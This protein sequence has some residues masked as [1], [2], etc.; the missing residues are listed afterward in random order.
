MKPLIY[1]SLQINIKSTLTHSFLIATKDLAEVCYVFESLIL[2][3][4]RLN[5]YILLE[6][7]HH[8]TINDTT[9]WTKEGIIRL[10]LLLANCESLEFANF[11]ELLKY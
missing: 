2:Q 4:K 1:K 6:G 3:T 7:Q 5:T 8:I 10:A 9:Y 11:L